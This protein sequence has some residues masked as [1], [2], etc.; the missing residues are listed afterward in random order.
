MGLRT[1]AFALV[2]IVLQAAVP[3]S[4]AVDSTW[5][6]DGADNWSNT[7]RWDTGVV[8]NAVDDTARLTFQIS[9]SRTITLDA[10]VTLGTL[11][12]GDA[13][14]GSSYTLS[15]SNA[16]TFQTSS[17]NA[18]LRKL[19]DGGTD[20]I[21]A[22]IVLNSTL[23][24]SVF[25]PSDNQVLILSG[26][27]SGGASAGNT[28]IVV[29]NQGGANA[30]KGVTRLDGQNTFTGQVLVQSGTLRIEGT[31]GG[32]TAANNTALGAVGAGNETIVV[33]G[34]RLDL[35][36]RDLN[37]NQAATEIIRISGTGLN[38]FGGNTERGGL[39]ALINTSGSAY[40]S[41]LELAGDATVGGYSELWLVEHGNGAGGTVNGILDGGGYALTK[42][43]SS[44]FY[45]RNATLSNL[46]AINV[47]EGEMRVRGSTVLS[48][49]GI[50]GGVNV[51]YNPD[52]FSQGLGGTRTSDP[53]APSTAANGDTGGNGI[54]EARLEFNEPSASLVHDAN[55][56]L[57]RGAIER[58][59]PTST[60]TATITTTLAGAINLVGGSEVGMNVFNIA[61]GSANVGDDP[62]A[63]II[64]GQIDNTSAGNSGV[65]FTKRGDRELRITSNQTA[66]DGNVVVRQNT[67]NLPLSNTGGGIQ[68]PVYGLTLTG[69]GA[70]SA[71]SSGKTISL[72]RRGS[73]HLDNTATNVANRISDNAEIVM[74]NGY[75]HIATNASAATTENLGTLTARSGINTVLL[76]SKAGGAIDISTTALNLT[77]GSVLRF[78]DVNPA[79]IFGVSAGNDRVEIGNAGALSLVGNTSGT[80]D[81]AV[82]LGVL[83][84]VVAS[85]TPAAGRA[86]QHLDNYLTLYSGSR[87]MTLETSGGKDYLRP[88][89]DAEFTTAATAGHNWRVTNS[90][91]NAGGR[92]NPINVASSM[93]V[94]SLLI[95]DQTTRT[96]AQDHLN[97]APGQTLTISSG[98][99]SFGSFGG[100]V[101]TANMESVLRGGF[102]DMNGQTALINSGNHW[103]DTDNDNVSG[104]NAYVRTHI[105]NA[106][107]LVKTGRNSVYLDTWNQFNAGSQAWVTEDNWLYVRHNNALQGIE[108]VNVSGAANFMLE[109]GINV[110]GAD[111]WVL[112]SDYADRTVLRSEYLHNTWSGDVILDTLDTTG[113]SEFRRSIITAN[114]DDILTIYGDI[115]TAKGLAGSQA[116]TTM[117]DSDTWGDPYRVSTS[118]GASGTINLRGRVRDTSTGPLD[119]V[120]RSYET[121]AGSQYNNNYALS[122]EMTG[123]NEM[124]V[125]VYQQWEATGRMELD[126]G[127]FRVHY[128]PTGQ[129]GATEG[130]L[131]DATRGAV[132]T[133][134]YWCRLALGQDGSGTGTAS[135]H[136]MLT[137]DGQLLNYPHLYVYNNDQQGTLT[138]G[139]ENM[140][141]TVYVGSR[142]NSVS[143]GIQYASQGTERDLR[144]YQAAGG[145]MVVNAQLDDESNEGGVVSSASKI[146]RGTV[147]INDNA[148]GASDVQAWNVMGGTLEWV[149]R[150]SGSGNDRF[151]RANND[152]NGA[153]L[154]LGGGTLHV[155]GATDADRDQDLPGA[156]FTLTPGGSE[157]WVTAQNAGTARTTALRVG[158][159]SGTSF[160]RSAGSL[161]NVIED[162]NGGTAYVTLNVS[163]SAAGSFGA[164]VS[165]GIAPWATHT[166]TPGTVDSFLDVGASGA[167]NP[168]TGHVDGAGQ[169]QYA[170]GVHPNVTG[171]I[172]FTAAAAPETLRFNTDGVAL[173]QDGYGMTLGSGG[174]LVTSAVTTGVSLSGGVL[175]SNFDADGAASG[176]VRDLI[177]HNYGG[178]V[179][180]IG[181]TITDN[182]ANAVNLVL[183]GT[184][185]TRLSGANSHTGNNYLVGGTMELGS[186]A[187]LGAVP[188]AA[189]ADNLYL[190]GGTL[191]AL[192]SFTINANRGITLG[193]EGG[194]FEVGSGTE[195][196]YAGTIA[197]EANYQNTANGFLRT[198]ANNPDFG[199]L[200]KTGAGTLAIGG[201]TVHNTYTGMTH[202]R[203][204]TLRIANTH[205]SEN[206]TQT[207]GTHQS[208]TDGTIIESGA[209][210]ELNTGSTWNT[211]E[212]ITLKGE[213]FNGGGVVRT[214]GSSRTYRFN[215]Q[216][217]L[218]GTTRF[219]ITNSATLRLGESG[220]G[221][222]SLDYDPATAD[223]ILRQGSGEL[224]FYTNSPDWY[225][226]LTA[227]GGNTRLYNG[228]QLGGMTAL[229]L[230]RNAF[231][232][233]RYDSS[234]YDWFTDRL[235]DAMPVNLDGRSRFRFTTSGNYVYSGFETIGAL[236][237]TG[238]DP[239]IQ[240]DTAMDLSASTPGTSLPSNN[241]G[242]LK[243]DS[244]VRTPGSILRFHQL[245]PMPQAWTDPADV[246]SAVGAGWADSTFGVSNYAELVT[247]AVG[248]APA[249]IGG[250][251]TSETSNRAIIP[252][253]LGGTRLPYVHANG[254]SHYDD[255]NYA[256]RR[257]MT[258]DTAIDP[259][260]GQPLTILRPLKTAE[261]TTLANPGTNEK[262]GVA[263]T[264]SVVSGANDHNLRLVGLTT[265][266]LGQQ[267][268]YMTG[269]RD[270][271]VWLQEDV[272]INSLAFEQDSYISD[273]PTSAG[274]SRGNVLSLDI[275]IGRALTISSG[276]IVFSATATSDR[277]GSSNDTGRNQYS[278]S[279]IHGGTLDFAGQEAILVNNGLWFHYNTS[280][281]LNAYRSSDADYCE[282]TI[283]ASIRNANGLTK[284]GPASI[285]L[286]GANEINGPV[287]INYG[288][289]YV[290]H[291]QALAGAT[292]INVT[293][294]NLVLGYGARV[295]GVDIHYRTADADRIALQ[296][297][298]ASVF[299]GDLVIHNVDAAG[300]VTGHNAASR[301]LLRSYNSIGTMSG[302]IYG[303]DDA[304]SP[305]TGATLPRLV[306]TNGSGANGT[307]WLRGVF[308][309]K[310]DSVNDLPIAVDPNA[311]PNDV[312]RFE[313]TGND[314]FQLWIDQPWH[315][316]G[317]IEHERGYVRYLGDGDFWHADAAALVDPAG[318]TSGYVMGGDS[319][320]GNAQIGLL[321]TKD[322][323][324]FNIASW[325]VG[326]EASNTTGNTTLGG[327]NTSGQVWYGTGTGAINFY[328]RSTAYDRDLTLVAARGGMVEIDAA[329]V[330]GGSNVNSSITKIRPGT[331]LLNGSSAGAG[332]VEGVN[333]MGGVLVLQNYS[334][335]NDRRIGQ[336]AYL[337]GGGGVLA[338]FNTS[339]VSPTE[340][341]TGAV[342][343][344][345]GASGV[346]VINA[347]AGVSTINL[348]NFTRNV[349]G[350]MA[351][352]EQAPAGAA[353]ITSTS[354]VGQAAGTRIGSWATYG[355]QAYNL[356]S[357]QVAPVVNDW[358]AYDGSSGIEAFSAHGTYS[359]DTFGA[360]LH[361]D[362]VSASV[363]TGGAT[364][365]SMRVNTASTITGSLTLQDGGILVGSANTGAVV[366]GNA[367]DTLGTSGSGVD[368]V[369]QN[370]GAGSLTIQSNIGGGQAFTHAGTGVTT[371]AGTNTYTGTS[372]LN[373][374]T[375][376]VDSLAR[377]GAGALYLGGATLQ[378]TGTGTD[379]N[380]RAIT[381]G[382][383]GAVI[384][385]DNAGV[386]LANRGTIASEANAISSYTVNPL[387][388]SVDITGDGTFTF[389]DSSAATNVTDVAGVNNTY[390]GLTVIGDGVSATTVR[391]EGQPGDY[392]WVTP[393]GAADTY[394]NST[395][396]R[397][398]ATLAFSPKRGD[399]S[400]DNEVRYR[401]WLVFGENA[402]DTTRLVKD[403]NR[404]VDLVGTITVNG[405]LE[406]SQT[407]NTLR[408]GLHENGSLIGDADS[409]IVK[410]GTGARTLEVRES[411]PDYKGAWEI[412]EGNIYFYGI[413]TPAGTGAAPI[414]LGDA[415]G[416][417]TGTNRLWVLSEVGSN[418]DTAYNAA[419][420]DLRLAQD[421]QVTGV[422]QDRRI[423]SSYL[424][425]DGATVSFDGNIEILNNNSSGRALYLEYEDTEGISLAH[426]GHLQHVYLAFNGDISFTGTGTHGYI[427]A[428]VNESG[429]ANDDDDVF[430]SFVL[431][432]NN[433][434]WN[435]E[436][437]VSN[438][439]S[440]DR[441]ENA[442][443]RLANGLALDADNNVRMRYQSSL[444][445]GGQSVT[446]GELITEAG[447]G[448][449]A[450]AGFDALVSGTNEIT[451]GSTA[452]IENASATPGSLTI[453]QNNDTTWD[454]LFRDG[455]VDAKYDSP[456]ATPGSLSLVKAGGGMAT[457]NNAMYHTGATTVAAG[458]L[459]VNGMHSGGGLYTV[460]SGATL[461]GVGTTDAPLNLYGTLAPGQ[462]VGQFQT[463][464][465]A[466]LPGGSF[467]FEI[468]NAE[469]T[470]GNQ[471]GLGGWDL[472]WIEGAQ[473]IDGELDLTGLTDASFQIEIDSLLLGTDTP[474]LA[475]N[476]SAE[477]RVFYAWDF[478]YAAGGILGFEEGDF[479]LDSSGFLNPVAN[480]LGQGLFG[481]R[482][483]PTDG[484]YLQITFS[485]AI[486]EPSTFL[487]TALG[488]LSLA[489]GGRRR[490][491]CRTAI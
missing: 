361:T 437:R 72:E 148:K 27:M 69:N 70:L 256:A 82:V 335:Y 340:D 369:V 77:Q 298:Q 333:V 357:G 328:N 392:A 282:A 240:F 460:Q 83:G 90:V 253:F 25:D 469:G 173:T 403:T 276:Q 381:L 412:R 278:Q 251:L 411:S 402:T 60:G 13:S 478:L 295:H 416:T 344:A 185:T 485:G 424:P 429:S 362:I 35:R 30:D 453:T 150:S 252:G 18:F 302:N 300:T 266:T 67:N 178:G 22:P 155:V 299:G 475:D 229:T 451:S 197:S 26:I 142:N 331:V 16:L 314:T 407:S 413:G 121:I 39:G 143:T 346:A 470:M 244:I 223:N 204:G 124:N 19:N 141:G 47:T 301:A 54:G 401:E 455:P 465:Q 338:M 415:T 291:D 406:I 125:N 137:R 379:T 254:T 280:D 320:T 289:L 177:I 363:A 45:L 55:I 12:I 149:W 49:A 257:A 396:I 120:I 428:Y 115:Y 180:E 170:A 258:V 463:A 226:S 490:R 398:N 404:T 352:A 247:V 214:V 292:E 356:A 243:F 186:D 116:A 188:G 84:G 3:G 131:T 390:Q 110:R 237:V 260:T 303:S 323:Q 168:F 373:Q 146:G 423:G 422:N 444:Q 458:T 316:A 210:L 365:A 439:T 425:S 201:T 385:L 384:Q 283:G 448:D 172:T 304:I 364:T 56:N 410:T 132:T 371:L 483:N 391:V 200:I 29:N 36:D 368:L 355:S 99:I 279:Y 66:F 293:G 259:A 160:Y 345:P 452:I 203:E 313:I 123:H 153:R 127:Y 250:Q 271:I 89:T 324:R 418:D 270:S 94:N 222:A 202:V 446:L 315:S 157:L 409:K 427:E 140:S 122:F 130:F 395:L 57:N 105:V 297:E 136:L 245:D 383:S 129:T 394:L 449:A 6:Y 441:D 265:D 96:T 343:I 162:A 354:G 205:T 156:R 88:L 20:Y 440:N 397:N 17:G 41:H 21:S 4:Y 107:G 144:L 190:N 230:Q 417:A 53:Y 179:F 248:T 296:L 389:G 284:A 290:R 472:Q 482:L 287:N 76:N 37:I 38:S 468:D 231:F 199:D 158:R 73:L 163:G 272:T 9:A 332:T 52:A 380:T 225:G 242:G 14:G 104:N 350:T 349:G 462:S 307:L 481:I 386:V 128:D 138:L 294:G 81:R 64:S 42:R 310:W 92:T 308:A 154:L 74:R 329:L 208:W 145:T 80:T 372:Y 269:R 426:T 101:S 233:I 317:R 139:G 194:A 175:T 187:A 48:A 447:T 181:S 486:P 419:T 268:T 85:A 8:P 189:V 421:I 471:G 236:T 442:V 184:G 318:S 5:N 306:S 420:E 2:L 309:D 374:G 433:S 435:G 61:G 474:G 285:I 274:T 108:Q 405:I 196:A 305:L 319:A 311:N 239:A 388:G 432:G 387:S 312:L 261:Y 216:T 103:H 147:T 91:G 166:T 102:L 367:G 193:G 28:A 33:Q 117:T 366:I 431:G 32:P 59:G 167:T 58:G 400:R 24:I 109:R 393:F 377:L 325:Q 238:G 443:L 112:P 51:F 408:L 275:G 370:Y 97:I 46:S 195:L 68:L 182:G 15:G 477:P 165:L 249:T 360:G 213:G 221:L 491:H 262:N 342:T 40:F 215:G 489:L 450:G 353:V 255:E 133:N 207:L 87:L 10:P 347:N 359:S 220:G 114:S 459:R 169:A 192:E 488:L 327:G 464:R 171:D 183:G 224:Q 113:V 480:A 211:Y 212:W 151:A 93:A 71:L 31:S 106:D 376:A 227:V 75:L 445:A 198:N 378:H 135:S 281:S 336:G 334:T 209:S 218:D 65:G 63:M 11:E 326:D 434:G 191:R 456:A 119:Q 273:N 484:H 161:L 206:T 467:E 111:L 134:S 50:S 473:A 164:L 351:F 1:L 219:N 264:S 79:A 341:L 438:N 288:S 34:G 118:L 436:L 126:R 330:D 348:G 246:K 234:S 479:V 263:L 43:G 286:Y 267:A 358:A 232:D 457:V 321:L 95:D 399:G 382:D 430:A 86:Q 98:M 7:A 454:V 174:I 339:A 476:F 461:G 44:Y 375:V 466:W 414:V 228:A 78:V 100:S 176:V 487:M 235:P 152:N 337:T 277:G 23:E 241:Y 217:F 62:G 322:G 159:G